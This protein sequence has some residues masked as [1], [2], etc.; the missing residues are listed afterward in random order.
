MVELQLDNSLIKTELCDYY[1]DGFDVLHIKSKG[2]QGKF[3][4]FE[5][6]NEAL[7]ELLKGKKVFMNIDSSETQPYQRKLRKHFQSQVNE[8]SLGVA[9]TS[10]TKI[11]KALAN[12][13]MA[14]VKASVPMRFFNSTDEALMWINEA[15]N[16]LALAY[17]Q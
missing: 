3:Y 11:G 15:K 8:F 1:L 6:T 17:N 10:K 4:Y 13:Y 9:I 2:A 14:L 12:L 7:R 5:E 16:E